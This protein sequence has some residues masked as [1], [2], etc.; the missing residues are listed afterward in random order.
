MYK[1]PQGRL[2]RVIALLVVLVVAGD[3]A[4]TGSYAQFSTYFGADG[5]GNVRQLVLGIVFTVLALGV[6]IGGIA[7]AGFVAKSADFLIEVEQEMVRVT[8]P[9]GPDLVRS[10]IVIAVMIIV[11]GIGIF[12]V[13]WVNLHLLEYLLQNKS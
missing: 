1:W 2:I 6:L 5:G 13:D 9:T 3:L 10:T 12:A 7:A 11:L 4:W 8:W